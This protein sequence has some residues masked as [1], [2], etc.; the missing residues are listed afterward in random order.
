MRSKFDRQ[1]DKLN[2]EL[3]E[4]GALCEN[5]IDCAIRALLNH[6]KETADETLSIEEEIN[7]I[8]KDIEG[9]CL[10]LL[11]QQQPVASDLRLISAALKMITDMERIGDQAADIAEIVIHTELMDGYNSAHIKKMTK[12]VSKMVTESVD[13]FVGSNL[14]LAQDVINRDDEVDDLFIEVNN[15]LIKYI[16]ENPQNFRLKALKM[17]NSFLTDWMRAVCRIWCCLI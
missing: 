2:R 3:I 14:E 4:M 11:L 13:A 7:Q 8:E 15:D 5:A 9:L 6:D 12:A 1:L 10:K 16:T 17:E